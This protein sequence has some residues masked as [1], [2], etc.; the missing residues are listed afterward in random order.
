MPIY[1][2]FND[3]SGLPV[4]T[5][6]GIPFEIEALSPRETWGAGNGNTSIVCRQKW[7]GSATWIRDMVGTVAVTRPGAQLVLTRNIPELIQYGDGRVQFCSIVDQVDQGGNASNDNFSQAG[8]NWPETDWCKYR[9]VF[10]V[11]PYSILS[12]RQRDTIA[13]DIGPAFAGA[14][15]LYRYVIR[16]RKTYSREQ[17]IPAAG[18]AGGF[19]VVDDS[20]NGPGARI[21]QVGFRV[22]SMADVTYKWVRVPIGWPPPLGW[23]PPAPTDPSWPWPSGV[24]LAVNPTGNLLASSGVAP[25]VTPTNPPGRSRDLYIGGINSTWIDA[26]APDGYCFAPGTLLYTGYDD[27]N[28]YYDAAGDWVCDVVYSFKWK[29]GGWDLFLNALGQ[30]VPVTDTG[31]SAGNPPYKSVQ[32]NNLFQHA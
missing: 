26:A 19:R 6:S 22:V 1:D 21:G 8:T 15:E 2:L 20:S 30:W 24:N 12:D 4:T 17:P 9:A 29:E 13:T 18:P 25:N 16:S 31:R 3:P 10:E 5:R 27:S 14:E 23:V 11:F 28:R 32:L 7:D